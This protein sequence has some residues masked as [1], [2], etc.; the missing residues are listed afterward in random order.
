M[1]HPRTCRSRRSSR[2]R[3]GRP[4]NILAGA[5]LNGDG[6]GGAFPPDRRARNPADPSPA[7]AAIAATLPHQAT[8]DLRVSRRF[9][10][11]RHRPRRGHLRGVQP[12]Q[13][14][15]LHRDQ[16]H[17]RHRCVSSES[18]AHVRTVHAGGGAAAGTAGGQGRLLIDASPGD[19][20]TL[21]LQPRTSALPAPVLA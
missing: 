20:T 8:V 10:L 3:S 21:G 2:S 7:S 17:L 19:L 12:V 16:Q 18:A 15:E 6:N 11:A 1:S 5:D 13:P 14:D 4:Y 9:P